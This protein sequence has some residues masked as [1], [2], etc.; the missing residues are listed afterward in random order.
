MVN[1][2][3]LGH[4]SHENT[5]AVYCGQ[6]ITKKNMCLHFGN[7]PFMPQVE[8]YGSDFFSSNH[9]AFMEKTFRLVCLLQDYTHTIKH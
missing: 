8:V 7:G 4:M 3:R 5:P 9:Q 6:P 2:D 1:L